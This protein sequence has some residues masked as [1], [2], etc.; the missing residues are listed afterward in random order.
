M[1]R[2][3]FQAYCMSL[4]YPPYRTAGCIFLL[5]LGL[6]EHQNTYF[7]L[8][9]LCLH[10][11][12]F[13]LFFFIPTSQVILCDLIYTL[14]L[15]YTDLGITR[16]INSSNSMPDGFK[17]HQ[18]SFFVNQYIIANTIVFTIWWKTTFLG[19]VLYGGSSYLS[20]GFCDEVKS[21]EEVDLHFGC[22][23]K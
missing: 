20:P 6:E 17:E 14:Y 2:A 3:C 23:T 16:H 13:F 15:T 7:V 10:F 22:I 19:A 1:C 18:S 5:P 4:V 9:N 8:N 11:F 12:F 21:C